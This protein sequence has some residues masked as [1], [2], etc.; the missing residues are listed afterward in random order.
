[1]GG[2]R[3]RTSIIWSG[4]P[5][6]GLIEDYREHVTEYQYHVATEKYNAAVGELTKPRPTMRK[7]EYQDPAAFA[8]KYRPQF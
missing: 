5:T 1:L 6:H 2:L 7:Q 8:V 4:W 3:P